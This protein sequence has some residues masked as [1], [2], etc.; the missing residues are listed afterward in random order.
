MTEVNNRAGMAYYSDELDARMQRAVAS[1]G[2]SAEDF[3][4]NLE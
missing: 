3:R 2:S 1:Y 4:S